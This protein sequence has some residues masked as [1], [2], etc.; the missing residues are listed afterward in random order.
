ME[1]SCLKLSVSQISWRPQELETALKLLTAYNF[2]GVEVAP[3]MLFGATPY[4][5]N[6]RQ[7]AIDFAT[8]IKLKYNL[9]VSSM[10]S[11]WYGVQGNI[12]GPER[13]FLLQY[14]K[15]AILFASAIGAS[16]IVFGCPKNRIIPDNTPDDSAIEFFREIS[17]FAFE[18]DTMLS[19]EANPADYGT[20]YMN[21]T[22]DALDV[23]YRVSSKSCKLN[24]DF[25]TILLN[26]ENVNWLRGKVNSIGHVHISEPNL[27]ILQKRNEHLELA[28][29]LREENYAGY[30]SIEMLSQPLNILDDLCCYLQEVFG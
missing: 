4:T 3:T 8:E 7:Q 10:Q 9:S 14:T 15:D 5:P 18:H 17:D 19:L 12:F 6:C 25:G 29:I 13:N 27:A 1:G 30:V 20:N 26:N 21:T 24:V 2:D 16:N 22:A 23:V 28:A 11:I